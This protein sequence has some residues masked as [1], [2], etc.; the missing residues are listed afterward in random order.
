MNCAGIASAYQ[1]IDERLKS[2]CTVVLNKLI[3]DIVQILVLL[4]LSRISEDPKE[5]LRTE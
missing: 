1:E 5:D 3:V 2:Y 4:S